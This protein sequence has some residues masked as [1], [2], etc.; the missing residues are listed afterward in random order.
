MEQLILESVKQY[1]LSELWSNGWITIRLFGYK[2]SGMNRC[3][4]WKPRSIQW[5]W[6]FC[7][8]RRVRYFENDAGIESCVPLKAKYESDSDSEQV[9]WTKD[10]KYS[11]KRVTS[12]WNRQGWITLDTC[13]FRFSKRWKAPFSLDQAL[14]R[15]S[16]SVLCTSKQLRV[17]FEDSQYG[18]TVNVLTRGSSWCLEPK[19]MIKQLIVWVVN[20]G[21]TVVCA[22]DHA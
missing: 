9:V 14:S 7:S 13:A 1:L 18:E 5:S 8:F 11:E 3:E 10:E 15:L 4:G 17:R 20:A 2:Y 21:M 12:T 6:F 22:A 19:H 16:S